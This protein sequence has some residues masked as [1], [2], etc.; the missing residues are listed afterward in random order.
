[1]YKKVHYDKLIWQYQ[2]DNL[3]LTSID[4]FDHTHEVSDKTQY[5]KKKKTLS[6]FDDKILEDQGYKESS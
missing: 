2:K 3:T 5:L 1:M 6:I 4:L